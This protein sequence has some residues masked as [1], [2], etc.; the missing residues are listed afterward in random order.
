MFTVYLFKYCLFHVFQKQEH[1]IKYRLCCCLVCV[2]GGEQNKSKIKWIFIFVSTIRVTWVKYTKPVVFFY[3]Q[4]QVLQNNTLV[5][6]LTKRSLKMSMMEKK[7][8]KI[9]LQDSGHPPTCEILHL[10]LCDRTHRK[11]KQE[12]SLCS[13]NIVH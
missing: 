3:F 6:I 10:T 2:C 12:V 8:K 1:G 7:K 5:V 11:E 9:S 4:Y 13:C